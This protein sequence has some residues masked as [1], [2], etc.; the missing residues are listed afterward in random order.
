M[1]YWIA[2]LAGG[3]WL[4]PVGLKFKTMHWVLPASLLMTVS[5]AALM[6]QRI[7]EWATP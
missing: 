6:A 5:G 1:S 3:L 2:Y 4:L 7:A